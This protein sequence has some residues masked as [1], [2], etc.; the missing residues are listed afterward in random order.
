MS[1]PVYRTGEERKLCP[2]NLCARDKMTSYRINVTAKNWVFTLNNWTDEDVQ[3]L[4]SLDFDYLLFG[5]EIAP[6]TGTPHLQGY[7]QFKKQHYYTKVMAMLR[8]RAY[9]DVARGSLESQH[10][11][12]KKEDP[13]YTEMGT[14]NVARGF[15]K[16]NNGGHS[17]EDRAKKN[18]RLFEGDLAELV[19]NGEIAF[20]QARAVKNCRQD[21]L[22]AMRNKEPI[23]D[24]DGELEHL[25]I[26]GPARVGKTTY[27]RQLIPDFYFK[28]LNKWWDDYEMQESVLLED[29]GKTHAC[30]G[31]FLKIW[32]DRWNFAGEMKFGRTGKIRPQKVVITSN[33]HPMDLWP[34][35]D[36]ILQPILGRVKVIH[37]TKEFAATCPPPEPYVP[38]NNWIPG[39]QER[40]RKKVRVAA[41]DLTEDEVVEVQPTPQVP[42]P[43][44]TLPRVFVPE[45][46]PPDDSAQECQDPPGQYAPTFNAP[47]TADEERAWE[48][49]NQGD[50]APDLDAVF[51]DAEDFEYVATPP[52]I[53][54][55][56][57]APPISPAESCASTVIYNPPEVIDVDAFDDEFPC[58][59]TED[60]EVQAWID[61][62]TSPGP[63]DY[64]E[65]IDSYLLL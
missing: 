20:C 64:Y 30:L 36:S 37:F 54:L 23:G 49:F 39:S 52:P 43:S 38:K 25:W 50:E 53:S 13:E 56:D 45:S 8:G 61:L 24:I 14:A 29:F 5:K 63:D 4:K 27:A 21:I 41:P 34:D 17:I 6:E 55:D 59:D 16:G 51:A 10:I 19:M 15:Q 65:D 7:V 35:D 26:W 62:T 42:R 33:Y 31:D 2:K 22:E 11:Y 46:P 48:L 47:Y 32:L 9:M 57:L 58:P 44:L 28:T 1:K 12:C 60:A 18:K 3:C 40:A